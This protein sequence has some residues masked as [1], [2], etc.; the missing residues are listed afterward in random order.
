[1]N[2][3]VF[4]LDGAADFLHLSPRAVRAR[5]KSK[6]LTASKSGMNGGGKLLIF[7]SSCI[8][9][10]RHQQQTHQVNAVEGQTEEKTEWQSSKGTGYGTVISLRQVGSALDKALAQ[11]T[12][13][14]P[15]S[16]MTS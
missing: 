1:M 3:E 8:E 9:Y 12:S 2:D 13:G 15:K 14:R 11:R 7:K 4:D 16:S 6:L 5:I 10:V